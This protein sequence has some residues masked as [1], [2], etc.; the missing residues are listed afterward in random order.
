MISASPHRYRQGGAALGV[1][2]QIIQR[3][4]HQAAP[5][6]RRGLPAILTLRHLAHL[7]G[8][9]YSYLR[10]IITR[11][12]DGYRTFQVRKRGGGSRHIA[13][14][15]PTLAEVQS[16][17][18]KKVLSKETPHSASMAY[19]RECSPARCAERH[20][21]ARWL[22]KV[23]IHDFFES[24]S[25][26]GAYFVF[27]RCG[28]QPLVAFQLA[29]LCTRT[30]TGASAEEPRWQPTRRARGVIRAYRHRL[31]GHLP[32]GAPTSPMLSNLICVALD[33]RLQAMADE[34]GLVYT[35]YSDDMVFSTAGD[36]DRRRALIV[37]ANVRRILLAFDLQLHRKK[38]T[39]APPGARK[40]VL[41]LLV[42]GDALKLTSELRRRISDH[43]R[44]VERFGLAEHAQHRHF[45]SLWG[46]VR[47]VDGLL[48]YAS[49]VD[50]VFGARLKARFQAALAK[51]GW[52][53]AG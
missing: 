29:R 31:M 13:V 17:L 25:E 38:V 39:I 30:S 49:S 51:E 47:H 5:P 7:T 4:L 35:R 42:D 34:A 21:G 8:A 2:L 10:Q 16:W 43:V 44:G 12:R 40:I 19:A 50:P 15:E 22:I 27:R 37:V 11:D 20:L 46:F 32:Q 45:V 3:A 1:P 33:E 36:F 24:L 41:G 28:Y 9:D 48:V 26:R 53:D 52:L 6:E 14:P 18:Q 23:D